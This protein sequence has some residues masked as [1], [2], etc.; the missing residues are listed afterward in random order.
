V[1]MTTKGNKKPLLCSS[2]KQ[3]TYLHIYH[4]FKLFKEAT[5][6]INQISH[7]DWLIMTFE[8]KFVGWLAA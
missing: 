3:I 2:G 5:P 4:F 6:S 8:K 7:G 1:K